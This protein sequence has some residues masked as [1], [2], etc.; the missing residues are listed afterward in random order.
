[1]D[2]RRR[3]GRGSRPRLAVTPLGQGSLGPTEAPPFEVV[4]I[5]GDVYAL[6]VIGNELLDRRND[7][8]KPQ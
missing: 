1:M 4:D 7:A 8:P 5:R 3:G 6:G 2:E